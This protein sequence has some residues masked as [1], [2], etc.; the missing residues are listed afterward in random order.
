M[1]VRTFGS[2]WISTFLADNWPFNTESSLAKTDVTR[3]R[4]FVK[5][6]MAHRRTTYMPPMKK[7]KP[8]R[9]KL[10]SLRSYILFRVAFF[11]GT[12]EILAKHYRLER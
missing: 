1:A 8:V 4:K 7:D 5:A 9:K 2:S 12:A 10:A 11:G 3:M 6:Q